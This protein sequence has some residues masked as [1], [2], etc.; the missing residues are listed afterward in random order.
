MDAPDY[1]KSELQD[2]L[3]TDI[4]AQVL[5]GIANE[6][7]VDYL[8]PT[9][10]SGTFSASGNICGLYNRLMVSLVCRRQKISAVP[11]YNVIF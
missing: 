6:L 5:R 11:E 8:G 1:I 10:F 9:S 3:L 4:T 7:K 2:F